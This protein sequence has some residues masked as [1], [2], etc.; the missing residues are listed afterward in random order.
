MKVQLTYLKMVNSRILDKN[1]WFII[2]STILI[3]LSLWFFDASN[4]DVVIQNYLFDFEKDTWL[5]NE[6]DKMGKFIFYNFPKA[7]YGLIALCCAYKAYRSSGKERRKFMLILLGL[8]IIPAIA[9]NIKKFTN[10]YCPKQL[11]IYN[12]TNPYVKILHSYPQ[13][14]VQAK[15][16]KCFPAGH[17]VAGFSFF[18]LFF[19]LEKKR[20][21]IL[22]LIGAFLSGW[23]LGFYQMI[24]GAHFLGDTVVAM[25]LCFLLAAIISRIYYS[26][27]QKISD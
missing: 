25:L 6:H 7:L 15:T 27:L 20:N 17:C 4:I 10:I 14:F 3:L 8:I 19:A 21:R 2:G 13:D 5:V 26:R 1:N 18:I 23:I 9:G 24:K 16:G 22:G 11:E 12:G